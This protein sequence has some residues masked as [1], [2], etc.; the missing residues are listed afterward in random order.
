MYAHTLYIIHNYIHASMYVQYAA[1]IGYK[2]IHRYLIGLCIVFSTT[3]STALLYRAIHVFRGSMYIHGV[4][5]YDVR[6][7]Q[8]R[9]HVM[10]TECV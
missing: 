4:S 2:Y 3:V 9:Q 6:G 10:S 5:L 1:P 7:D 8:G